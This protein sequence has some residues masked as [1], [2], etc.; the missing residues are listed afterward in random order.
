MNK[1]CYL[2]IVLLF[3]SCG[4]DDGPTITHEMGDWK[5]DAFIL[6][7]V[8]ATHSRSEGAI[9]K[10]NEL[11]FGGETFD[12]YTLSL[13]SDQTFER[14]I[15]VTGPNVKTNGNWQL[16]GDDLVLTYKDSRDEDQEEEYKITKNESDQLWWSLKSNFLLVSNAR[17]DSISKLPSGWD[18]DLSA[19]DRNKFYDQ[20][21]LDLVFTF[22]R[23]EN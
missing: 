10:A 13:N 17:L 9:I 2:L 7:N 3:F 22:E 21:S 8:P 18:K 15:E 16:T 12:S 1:I 14:T 6:S 23:K 20:V 4:K 19:D 11:I 5:L